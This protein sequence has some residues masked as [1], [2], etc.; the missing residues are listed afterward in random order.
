MTSSSDEYPTPHT[1]MG[2]V[3]QVKNKQCVAGVGNNTI[4]VSSERKLNM[5]QEIDLMIVRPLAGAQCGGCVVGFAN[6][7]RDEIRIEKY[8]RI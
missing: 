2:L 3:V 7:S 8:G 5:N 1:G 6:K 4:T